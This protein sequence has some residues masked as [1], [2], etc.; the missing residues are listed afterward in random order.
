MS[1]WMIS[2][3]MAAAIPFIAAQGSNGIY[4]QRTS[5]FAEHIADHNHPAHGALSYSS[6]RLLGRYRQSHIS[7]NGY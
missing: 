7:T 6:H 4:G 3:S 1:I 2:A 5:R